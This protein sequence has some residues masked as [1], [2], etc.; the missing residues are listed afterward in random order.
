M[1]PIRL[2]IV[3]G[4]GAQPIAVQID[5]A[6]WLE[7]QRLLTLRSDTDAAGAKSTGQNPPSAANGRY[8][9]RGSV[10]RYDGPFGP[11]V[12]DGD[13]EALQ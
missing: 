1:S 4:E 9:L 11:A 8:P 5:Y 6:D 2:K 7:I 12:D 10:V 3:T 13:W